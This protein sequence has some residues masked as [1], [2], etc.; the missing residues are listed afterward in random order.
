MEES[1]A[2]FGIDLHLELT[3]R[4]VRAG[5][6]AGLRDAVR[7]GRLRPGARVPSSRTLAKDLGVARNTVA[8]AYAQLIAEGWFTARPGSGTR[9]T[10]RNTAT[11]TVALRPVSGTASHLPRFSFFPGSPDLASFPRSGWLAASRRALNTAPNAALGYSDPRGRVELRRALA[12]YLS[13]ARGVHADPNLIV[14]CSGFSQGLGLLCSVLRARGATTLGVEEYGLSSHRGAA[15]AA[16]LHLQTL[17]IDSGGAAISA[18]NG[19]DA[20]LLTPAHQFPLGV[21][22]Q[23][24]RRNEAVRWAR[25]SAGLVIE[26][27]YDGEFRYDRQPVGA[28]QALA[29]GHVVYAGSTSKSLA[30]GLRLGWLVLPPDLIDDVTAAK[31][32]ADTQTGTLDQLTL[33]EFITSGAYDH[34]V[35]R[36]RLAYRRRRDRL[37]TAIKQQ[38]PH[39]R[40]S[41]VAAG[42]HAILE[43]PPELQEQEVVAR[44]ARHGLSIQG[45]QDYNATECKRSAALVVGYG[46]PPPHA[47]TGALA[48]LCAVLN[49]A[50]S[51]P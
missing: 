13:R 36:C 43:L 5:L 25:A 41:G 12:D 28:L 4:R 17:T 7:T 44:A 30:P 35:R 45:L 42:L 14:V 26:D 33:A 49:V 15:V 23:P 18:A 50:P 29:P 31:R 32:L 51:H 37:A 8:D 2:T 6:E 9:V 20:I 39:V 47:F 10:D 24:D 19:A 3:G 40:I 48:R 21:V 11:E 16:G 38:A 1:W 22:L 34:H 46:S 27:D